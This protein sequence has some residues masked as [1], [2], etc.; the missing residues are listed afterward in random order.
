MPR[1]LM[2]LLTAAILVASS[3]FAHSQ[4]QNETELDHPSPAM[5]GERLVALIKQLDEA[6][7]G[8][9]NAWQFAVEQR[10]MILVFDDEADRMRLMS[11][12]I[13]TA[14]LSGELAKRLL[15]ANFDSALDARY[16]VGNEV[17]WSVFIHPLSPLTDKQFVSAVTQ[18]F[19]AADTFGGTYS[20]GAL[21]YQGGDSVE[22]YQRLERELRRRT[23]PSI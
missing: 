23:A 17:V 4:A 10:Q 3:V 14:D 11:P 20:S 13:S 18:I 16:A 5:T 21:V 7:R 2:S 6:A 1:N 8:E 15:T 22:E 12:I 9:A 19:M